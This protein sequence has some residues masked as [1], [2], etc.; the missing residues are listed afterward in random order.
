MGDTLHVSNIII[1]V[2]PTGAQQP[3]QRDISLQD[4]FTSENLRPLS[5]E[6]EFQEAVRSF[7]PIS[8]EDTETGVTSP[9]FQQVHLIIKTTCIGLPIMEIN[10][11]RAFV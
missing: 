10:T 6:K 7:L 11:A 5:H 3:T 1:I 2:G 4:M 9:Q 8:N